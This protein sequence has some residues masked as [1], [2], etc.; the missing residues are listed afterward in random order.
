MDE[1]DLKTVTTCLKDVQNDFKQ[2]FSEDTI[3][4]GHSLESDLKSLRVR[5]CCSTSLGLALQL[6]I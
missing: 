5:K 1:N 3:F 2:R 4:V 6:C